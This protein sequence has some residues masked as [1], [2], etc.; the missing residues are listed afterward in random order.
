MRQIGQ[1]LEKIT[2]SQEIGLVKKIMSRYNERSRL[3]KEYQKTETVR[4]MVTNL[5]MA[6][7]TSRV[8]YILGVPLLE[9]LASSIPFCPTHSSPILNAQRV[10]AYF[11][12]PSSNLFENLTYWSPAFLFSI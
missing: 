7:A 8:C 5:F 10:L 9:A 6:C 3:D 2:L 4:T 1:Y 11:I 12:T